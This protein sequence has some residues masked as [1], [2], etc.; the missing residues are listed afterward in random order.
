MPELVHDDV[1][2]WY[3]ERGRN[4]GRTPVVLLH[5]LL[6]SMRTMEGLAAQLP[7]RRVYLLDLRGHGRSSAPHD[8]DRYGRDAL[9]GDLVAFL[10][11]VGHQRV[12]MGGMS[13][14]AIATLE[15][16]LRHPERLEAMI[17]EM[18]VFAGGERVGRPVFGALARVFSGL[19]PVGDVARPVVKRVP[20][21]SG[22]H[23]VQWFRDILAGDHRGFS[24]MLRGL[25]KDKLD[26][27]EADALRR[28][29]TPALV[30]GHGQG[31]AS[32]RRIG[33][34]IH[35]LGDV[36]DA[37]EHLPNARLLRTYTFFDFRIRPNRLGKAVREF[38]V[39]VERADQQASVES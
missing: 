28:I 26:P 17:L 29:R 6:F 2:L 9:I 38:L 15:L 30:V 8:P 18:P 16:A 34:P 4:D 5:G 21:P 22:A 12:V 24:A 3:E 32:D 14:G 11:H 23:W 7:N 33:D 31:T 19:A 35:V 13:L 39:E 37:A 1:T 25:L 20:L 36:L 27:V 10:D